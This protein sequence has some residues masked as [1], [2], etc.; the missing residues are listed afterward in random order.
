MAVEGFMRAGAHLSDCAC[1]MKVDTH[2]FVS[3]YFHFTGAHSRWDLLYLTGTLIDAA[4][5]G[6][7]SA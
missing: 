4:N 6:A 2:T 5:A 7:V 3:V 1:K